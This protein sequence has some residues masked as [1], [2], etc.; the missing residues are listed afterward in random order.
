MREGLLHLGR[1]AAGR[2]ERPGEA[3]PQRK[4]LA[5]KLRRGG[6]PGEDGQQS[7][8]QLD[9]VA[10]PAPGLVEDQQ[11]VRET[12]QLRKILLGDPVAPGDPEVPGVVGERVDDLVPL[13]AAQLPKEPLGEL[14]VVDR[15][16]PADARA[17][18]PIV[19][20]FGRVVADRLEHEQPRLAV[21][22]IDL[23]DEALLQQ[24]GER[25]DDV[26][27]AVRAVPSHGLDGRQVGVLEYGKGLEQALLSGLEQPVAPVDGR[28][29][30]VLPLG[31]VPS[32][33]AKQV[34]AA[35]QPI[36]EPFG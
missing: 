20:P 34:E 7:R 5:G 27:R 11:A 30:R 23:A 1:E 15:V 21:A 32:R 13:R 3:H 14:R 19:E 33:T 4:L 17:V 18:G 16:V 9:R 24:R 35:A 28:P 2:H 29:K 36:A 26:D 8:G 10:I 12:G 22:R 25:L 31:Q 6:R